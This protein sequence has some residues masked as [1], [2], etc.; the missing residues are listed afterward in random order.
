MPTPPETEFGLSDSRLEVEPALMVS[1]IGSAVAYAEVDVTKVIEVIA[2]T[3]QVAA[4][5][6]KRAL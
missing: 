3:V 4:I 5:A 2:T 1:D 6:A